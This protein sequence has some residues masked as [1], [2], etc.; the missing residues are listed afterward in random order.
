MF[1]ETINLF[2]NSRWRPLLNFG[3]NCF[4]FVKTINILKKFKMA[5]VAILDFAT[6]EFLAPRVD[7]G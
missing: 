7:S 6:F 5:A 3:E 2:R 4:K 1:P